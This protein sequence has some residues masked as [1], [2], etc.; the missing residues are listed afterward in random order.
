MATI[1]GTF[2]S[3]ISGTLA[4]AVATPG[5]QG[6][7]GVQGPTGPQGLAAS[8]VV[9]TVTTVA[10]GSPA[11]VTNV[12][13]TSSAIFNFGLP[14]GVKGDKGDTGETGATGPAGP[15]GQGIPSGGTTG[16]YLVKSSNT[17]YDTAWST[18]NL[19]SYATQSWVNAQGFLTS[20][21]LTGYATQ[22]WVTTQLGSY[23][24]TSTAASTYAPIAHQVPAG[25]TTGQILA[26]TS[27]TDW[28]LGW[29]TIVPGDRYLTSSTTSLIVGNGTKT[30]TVGTGLSYSPQQD[31]IIAYDGTAHM[32]GIVT[33]YNSSTGS[34]IV[35]VQNHTGSG[36]YADW[37]VNVGGTVPVQAVAWGSIEGTLGD[38]SDLSTALNAKLDS[39]TAASTYYPLSGNPSGF[40]ADAP[41]D[42]ETYGRKDGAWSIVGG[43]SWSGGSISSDIDYTSVDQYST[44]SFDNVISRDSTSG[45]YGQIST[46]GCIGGNTTSGDYTQISSSGVR[47]PNGSVQTTAAVTITN[48]SALV[49]SVNV[50][51]SNSIVVYAGYIGRNS[52]IRCTYGGYVN[53]YLDAGYDAGDQFLFTNE[54][55]S[56][57]TFNGG[58]GITVL[59]PSGV[60]CV[61]GAGGVVAA[62]CLDG[63]TWVITGDL[64]PT[65]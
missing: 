17:S 53:V 56:V 19:S 46:V 3:L 55:G 51:S 7:P 61:K 10:A 28:A 63:T 52:I 44:F 22:S 36:T 31:V 48:N 26:K 47:F 33:T 40:I 43:G 13:N 57:I 11:T 27:S 35:N 21:S 41:S 8:I 54:T 24:T 39:T 15:A 1:N 23:L 45:E 16:Q 20:S 58:S 25:G 42:G 6:I 50:V 29:T 38:Q 64:T 4:G 37:I 30:L 2:N 5:P 34:L 49:T 12:G 65:I 32:H 9:G 62:T 14:Q 18:L 60:F 59:A